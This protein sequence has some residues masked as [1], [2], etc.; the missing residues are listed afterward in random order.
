MD[1]RAGSFLGAAQGPGAPEVRVELQ[2]PT[3]RAGRKIVALIDTGADITCVAAHLVEPLGYEPVTVVGIVTASGRHERDVY[4]MRLRFPDTDPPHLA[5]AE[6]AALPDLGQEGRPDM[7]L[8]RDL[9]EQGSFCW[10]GDGTTELRF[11]RRKE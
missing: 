10:H 3:G 1:Y 2:G 8:G 7:L 11:D 4:R 6:V 5:E 9:L